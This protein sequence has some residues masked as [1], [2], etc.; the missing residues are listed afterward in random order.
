MQKK[1]V[2]KPTISGFFPFLNDWGTIGSLVATLDYS[3]N[4]IA[5]QYEIIIVDDGSDRHSKDLLKRLKLRLPHL[6]IINHRR[7]RGYGGAIK[8][9]ISNAKYEWVFYTDG[10]A[11]YNPAEVALLAKKISP[12]VDVINGYKIQRDDP[13]YRT[14]LGKIYHYTVKILFQTPIRDTDCD[15]RLM[16]RGI[17]DNVVLEE[18]TGVICTEM[19]KKISDAGYLFVEVPVHHF[20]RTSS[21]SQIFNIPRVFRSLTGLGKLWYKLELKTFLSVARLHHQY[22]PESVLSKVGPIGLTIF[23]F[24]TRR[25]NI[26]DL[27]VYQKRNKVVGFAVFLLWNQEI[28]ALA[29]NQKYQGKGI[30]TFLVRQ[31]MRKVRLQ[32]TKTI[33]VKALSSND[34]VNNFYKQL[35]FKFKQTEKLSGKEFNCYQLTSK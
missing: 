35:G 19:I 7:N 9:G 4:Q 21:K 2:A 14:I 16:R 13:W 28:F 24:L 30:G 17:F 3:L 20:W 5:S 1:T 26:I 25:L 12:T 10:D 32:E 34:S 8:T 23:Y 27:L 29:V 15:F 6:R 11:Q 22:L 33:S 18:N 31:I